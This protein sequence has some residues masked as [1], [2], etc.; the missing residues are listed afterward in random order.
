MARF[1]QHSREHKVDIFSGAHSP[2]QCPKCKTQWGNDPNMVMSRPYL[3][4]QAGVP[5][6]SV[7]LVKKQS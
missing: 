3:R 1:E 5:K 7:I 6:K 4:V 2:N